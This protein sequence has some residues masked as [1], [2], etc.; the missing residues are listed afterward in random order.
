MKS[1]SIENLLTWAF[2]EELPKVGS[3][4]ALGPG[5]VP[6]PAETVSRVGELGTTVDFELN[7]YGVVSAFLDMGEPHQ[8]A[9]AVGDAVRSMAHCDGFE[10]PAGWNPFPGYSEA[11]GTVRDEC[12]RIIE[13]YETSRSNSTYGRQV[14]AMIVSAAVLRHGPVWEGSEP[15][16][17]TVRRSNKDVW[18]VKRRAKTSLGNV[19][20]YEDNG[21]DQR[22]QRPMRGA[23]RKYHLVE[24]IRST[25][26][27]RIDWQLWQSALGQLHH[28]LSGR[29]AD[30]D[31]LP[32]RLNWQPWATIEKS[33]SGGKAIE[34]A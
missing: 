26:L 9:L 34:N 31:L 12:A 2:T 8:D 13:E 10:I 5:A 27:A 4:V 28:S 16:V 32:F 18:F 30:H 24:P 3:P 21:F 25:V 22:K 6:S 14:V 20:E 19:V 29:L 17:A 33:P 23:Y 7:K 11:T 15:K 1:V